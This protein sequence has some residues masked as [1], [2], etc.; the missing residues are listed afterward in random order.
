MLK[1]V[2]NRRFS[3]HNELIIALKEKWPHMTPRH[4]RFFVEYIR[5]GNATKSYISTSS[6][7]LT[8]GAAGVLACRLLRTYNFSINDFLD[9]C[10]HSEFAI[11]EALNL[12]KVVD[13]DKY[14]NHIE[15]LRKLDSQKIEI[16]VKSLP[17]LEIVTKHEDLHS[18]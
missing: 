11:V 5:T 17:V 7:K 6:N 10:G 4:L 3:M 8:Y 15:K 2:R 16:D 9:M 1:K 12:L 18:S 13:P 14:L